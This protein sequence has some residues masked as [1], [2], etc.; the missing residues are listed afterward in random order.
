MVAGGHGCW[1]GESGVLGSLPLSSF[2]KSTPFAKIVSKLPVYRRGG[3]ALVFTLEC[4]LELA[5]LRSE[6]LIDDCAFLA[7]SF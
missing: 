2:D 7:S 6:I 4:G 1:G 3:L 5:R